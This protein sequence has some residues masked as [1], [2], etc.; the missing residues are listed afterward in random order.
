MF[1]EA[2]LK[3]T[4][5]SLKSDK[6]RERRGRLRDE[7]KHVVAMTQ[8][9]ERHAVAVMQLE[10]RH[11]ADQ[12]QIAQLKFDLRQEMYSSEDFEERAADYYTQVQEQVAQEQRTVELEFNNQMQALRER[13]AAGE[14]LLAEVDDQDVGLERQPLHHLDRFGLLQVERDAPLVAVEGLEARGKPVVV[15]AEAVQR[16]SLEGFDLDHVGPHVGQLQGGGRPLDV[17][18]H[19]ENPDAFEDPHGVFLLIASARHL[20][21]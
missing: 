1:R 2:R 13:V 15:T 21:V 18:R 14:Q 12:E 20:R 16:V 5:K 7:L 4:I 19:V 17:G 6:G 8:L 10:E 3:A 11:A 9:E